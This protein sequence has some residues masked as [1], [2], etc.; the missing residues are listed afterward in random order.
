MS[1]RRPMRA[2]PGRTAAGGRASTTAGGRGRGC[3]HAGRAPR[4][5]D[6]RARRRQ[7]RD[8]APALPLAED[9]GD[10]SPQ[11]LP[12]ARPARS[13]RAG[14][15]L[16]LSRPGSRTACMPVAAAQ[17]PRHDRRM[18]LT[19]DEYAGYDAIGLRELIAA[20]E[21]TIAEV[22]AVA[23]RALE[24]ANARVNGLAAPPFAPALEHANDGPLSGV[25][26]LIT[27]FGPMAEGVPFFCGSRGV[28]GV[29]PDHDS[30]LMIRVRAAGLATLGLTTAPEVGLGFA[31]EP[32]RTG[33][34]RNPWN[35]ERGVGGS[36]GG[37]AALVAA[38]AVPIA[39]GSDGAGS[40]RI[41]AS[42]CGLVGLKPSRG[43]TPSGPD[44]GSP[45]FGLTGHFGLTRSVRDAAHY[46]DAIHGPAVGDPYT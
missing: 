23:R 16:E 20:R 27:D 44:I 45:L 39:H 9:G 19:P 35:L 26:F 13:Q 31:T 11:R 14:R 4:G 18:T 6:R 3:A 43:R 41:P 42:C 2:G 38:G 24:A 30:D 34:T 22:E 46:L 25:P 7:P 37:S 40:L 12:Q 29:R 33:P 8:R 5:R 1:R 21:V 28:P 15:R 10:A 32:L 36:S 17:R